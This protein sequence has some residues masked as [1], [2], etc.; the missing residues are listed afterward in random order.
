V[1]FLIV[2]TYYPA[3]LHGL[4]AQ[5][6]ALARCPYDEQ[7]HA[8]M[9]Q[10]FGT[11]D[12]YSANLQKLG[13]EAT[14]IVANCR[15][16]QLQWAREQGVALRRTFWRRVRGVPVPWLDKDWI[17]PV[18]M[19]QIKAYRPDVI[20][21]QDPGATP[22]AFLKE[23]RPYVRL[24]T[25]QIAS[26]I[27]P[28]ADFRPYDLMLSSFPHFVERFSQL[29]LRSAY[30]RLGF[31]PRVLQYLERTETNEVVF[32]GGVSRAHAE[33]IQFLEQVAQR[34]PVKWWGY[35]V[36]KLSPG[37]PLRASFQ[38][39][40]WALDMYEKLFNARIA[41]NHHISVSENY[42]NN[43][44]LYEATGVGSLLLTDDKDNLCDLFEPGKEIV[45][46]HTAEE[47]V[48]LIH[49]YLEHEDERQAIA[50]AGQQHTLREHTYYHRMQEFIDLVRLLLACS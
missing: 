33:R 25:G 48:T 31:E 36:D 2:D 1:K 41:L 5:R 37:S 45:A 35:G 27:P 38:G 43:M 3:F 11:A 20:H 30:F 9:D 23:V 14:E 22:A 28:W 47:C 15:P 18:L 39:T 7:W 26:P 8:L 10:C 50:R 42:A 49:Y 46:Y 13:H 29:G 34:V 6:P 24:I 40:A 44:R 12:F 16:L 17:Y 4:Y 19:A 32:I 21:F